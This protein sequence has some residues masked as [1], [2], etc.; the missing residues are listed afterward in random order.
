MKR[1]VKTLPTYL[2]IF[3]G[4]AG[5]VVF[6]F[7]LV[8]VEFFTKDPALIGLLI[9]GVLAT[10]IG[11]ER[12]TTL[13][14]T[15]S[16][17]S[18]IEAFLT[19]TA[20]TRRVQGKEE[21]YKDGIRLVGQAE[22]RIRSVLVG[23]SMKAPKAFADAV[24]A[25]LQKLSKQGKPASMVVILVMQKSAL[26]TN[27]EDLVRERHEIYRRKG[28]GQ[29]VSVRLIDQENPVGMDYLIIDRRHISISF[30][31]TAETHM[32]MSSIVIEDQPEIAEQFAD[33]FDNKLIPASAA[34]I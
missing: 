3:A 5:V 17:I 1:A 11:I 10:G 32:L 19:N 7:D 31:P 14:R 2:L 21:I 24:A 23:D 8:G 13:G 26:P 9:L 30:T 29:F 33:W 34:L 4:V 22:T 18:A 15:E 25:R 27:F 28:V 16:A 20:V 12:A 6:V